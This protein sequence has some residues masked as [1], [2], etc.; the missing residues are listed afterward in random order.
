VKALRYLEAARLEVLHEA[1]FYAAISL[2]LVEQFDLCILQA[3]RLA[4]EFP[5]LGAPY[6]YGT[7]R[8]F[9][10]DFKFSVVYLVRPNEIVVVAIAPFK[11]KPGYWRSRLRVA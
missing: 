6:L 3:E 8:V 7:R 10:G 9:P 2:K 4:T 5:G 11:R 1:Q